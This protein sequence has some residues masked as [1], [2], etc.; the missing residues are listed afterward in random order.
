MSAAAAAAVKTSSAKRR[1]PANKAVT[2]RKSYD[3]S[4]RKWSAWAKHQQTRYNNDPRVAV[5]L[6]AIPNKGSQL[7]VVTKRDFKAGQIVAVYVVEVVDEHVTS[8]LGTTYNIGACNAKGKPQPDKLGIITLPCL[9]DDLYDGVPRWGAFMNEP[10]MGESVNV[11]PVFG[12]LVH[13]KP[14][15][16][17]K[18]ATLMLTHMVTTKAVKAGQELMWCYGA[19]YER[20]YKTPCGPI[21]VTID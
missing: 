21:V 13:L 17:T 5:Q 14:P 4:K 15:G 7:G 9:V 10:C 3:V 20:D 12:R 8:P 1:R 16:R 19:D 2:G 18:E 11:R 6:V